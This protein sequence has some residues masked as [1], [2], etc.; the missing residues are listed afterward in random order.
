MIY[1]TPVTDVFNNPSN[2]Y[3][4]P[5]LSPCVNLA[6]S[7]NFEF[8]Q[9]KNVGIISGSEILQNM[10]L[11]N[12]S[13]GVSEWVG[14]SQTLQSG[15]IIYIP[16][17]TKGL[18]NKIDYFDIPDFGYDNQQFYFQIDL[19]V[20]YFSN[21]KKVYKNIDASANYSLNLDISDAL[22]IEFS[23][24]IGITSIYDPSSL[25]FVG[26]SVG[27]GFEISNV[28]LNIIDA[29]M[30]ENSP[31][32]AIVIDNERVNQYYNLELN[33]DISLPAMKYPNGAM[34]GYIMQA[35]YPTTAGREDS[36]L[37]INNVVSPFDVYYQQNTPTGIHDISI[38]EIVTF[39]PSVF[40]GDVSI[41]FLL[42]NDVSIIDLFTFPTSD[43]DSSVLT[44]PNSNIFSKTITNSVIY[45]S[46]IIQNSSIGGCSIIFNQPNLPAIQY[47]DI[48]DT[49]II[50]TDSSSF[51]LIQTNSLQNSYILV[52]DVS[53]I[54]TPSDPSSMYT[55]NINLVNSVI[56]LSSIKTTD[57]FN[58]LVSNNSLL[59]QMI[60]D[61]NSTFI[62]D[63]SNPT[64]LNNSLVFDSSLTGVEI[65]DTY[66]ANSI[67]SKNNI[68]NGYLY[69]DNITDSSMSVSISE[70]SNLNNSNIT[71]SILNNSN[72][73][74][75]LIIDSSLIDSSTLNTN[76]QSSYI[77]QSNLQYGYINFS[78]I[79][80]DLWAR[81]AS[82]N[83]SII[84]NSN[85]YDVSLYNST[86]TDCSLFNCNIIDS[87]LSGSLLYNSYKN[88]NTYLD[89]TSQNIFVNSN[90]DCSVSWVEDT[91]SLYEKFSKKV[92]VGM[93]S[94]G[95]NTVLSA[96]EYLDYINGHDMWEKFGPLQAKFSTLDPVD[97]NIKNLIGGFYVF[98]PHEFQ[99]QIEYLLIN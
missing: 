52:P 9:K 58:S 59:G 82:L 6:D 90:T 63:A 64:E 92:D 21:F 44:P 7:N 47:N 95:D 72:V 3:V 68:N 29:S 25:N 23:T 85:I 31:F 53:V 1:T 14:R 73:G 51:I 41:N 94:D 18:I 88:E 56:T 89:I 62:I 17:L 32:P 98:N 80:T 26:N 16:G 55:N 8:L 11:S 46:D 34:L 78:E 60:L 12:I 77:E 48:K 13:I 45:N 43:I 96:G 75:S 70:Q 37:Y 28:V 4:N 54:Y 84:I 39:D 22:N 79:A 87:S 2:D 50:G 27:F 42:I 67:L 76:Y 65:I 33:T 71:S 61:D 36:W 91:S 49:S 38:N 66:I 15:E 10:D 93:N 97:S 99:V 24:N 69:G 86:I 81:D 35:N 40:F 19:S 83:R 5:N 74:D 57:I 20:N 30:D